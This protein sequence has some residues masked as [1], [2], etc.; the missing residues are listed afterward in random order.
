MPLHPFS[1]DST[2]KIVFDILVSHRLVSLILNTEYIVYR[3]N[4][5]F[6]TNIFFLTCSS[7]EDTPN[8]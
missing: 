7:V 8:I 6:Q 3:H 5:I 4:L 2:T 1:F